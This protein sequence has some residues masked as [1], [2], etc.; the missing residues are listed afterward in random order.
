MSPS[1]IS[2]DSLQSIATYQ[3]IFSCS[4]PFL[5]SCPCCSSDLLPSNT[6]IALTTLHYETEADFRTR[7]KIISSHYLLVTSSG[8]FTPQD[9]QLRCEG[10]IGFLEHLTADRVI[11]AP[12]LLLASKSPTLALLVLYS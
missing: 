11:P 1:L 10:G 9:Q 2:I 8:P 3:Q 5:P 6:Y 12:L 7:G 4:G